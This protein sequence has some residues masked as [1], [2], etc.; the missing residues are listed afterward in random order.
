MAAMS[1]RA[2]PRTTHASRRA[3]RR[4]TV[5][6]IRHGAGLYRGRQLLR[7]RPAADLRHCQRSAA[8]GA[9]ARRKHGAPP[10]VA[11]RDLSDGIAYVWTTP[12]LLA[13]RVLAFLVNLTAYPLTNGLCPT[14]PRRSIASTRPGLATWSPASPS[15]PLLGSVAVSMNGR[16]I[17]PA[18]T[19]IVSGLAW[20][21]MLLVFAQMQRPVRRHGDAHARR[22]RAKLLHGHAVVV[23]LRI[24][25]AFRGRVMGVRMLAIYSLPLGLLVAGALIDLIGFGATATLYAGRSV[26]HRGDCSALA[27][28]HL[29]CADASECALK[30]AQHPTRRSRTPQLFR[31]ATPEDAISGPVEE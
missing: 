10:A 2:R 27:C 6:G 1:F 24:T 18:R 5:R 12:Q 4:G 8:Q 15:A 3:G 16:V 25:S 22:L 28:R 7:A 26:V 19:M 29:A 20:Y 30:L 9:R 31:A 17:R 23:L 21:V 13:P 11:W 14:S